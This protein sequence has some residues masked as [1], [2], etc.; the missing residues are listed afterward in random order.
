MTDALK[1]MAHSVLPP[2][3]MKTLHSLLGVFRLLLKLNCSNLII[4]NFSSY[5][6]RRTVTPGLHKHPAFPAFH[7]SSKI[8][9]EPTQARSGGGAAQVLVKGGGPS[10]G[11]H[12]VHEGSLHRAYVSP[13]GSLT[14]PWMTTTPIQSQRGLCLHCDSTTARWEHYLGSDYYNHTL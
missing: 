7:C 6:P 8:N 10:A 11:S 4:L 9:M 2:S 5:I 13:G 12:N 3:R 14:A 1:L